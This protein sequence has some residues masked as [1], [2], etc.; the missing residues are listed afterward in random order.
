L[1][2]RRPFIHAKRYFDP[3]TRIASAAFEA[4]AQIVNQGIAGDAVFALEETGQK[5]PALATGAGN[6]DHLPIKK[7]PKPPLAPIRV[8]FGHIVL[9]LFLQ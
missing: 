9:Y 1:L 2:I 6:H 3:A 5:M 7:V 8:T 4:E